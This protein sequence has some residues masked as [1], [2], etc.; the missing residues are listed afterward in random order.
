MGTLKTYSVVFNG[1]LRDC[2]KEMLSD[3]EGV[4][5]VYRCVYHSEADAV[6]L[7]E[8]IYIGKSNDCSIKQ[9]LLQKNFTSK[10]QSGEEIC[11]SL[12]EVDREDIDIVANALA[13]VQKPILNQEENH[14]YKNQHAHFLIGGQCELLK[15]TQFTIR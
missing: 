13:Y 1:Y 4:Y 9:E 11:Y 15:R 2:N 7:K 5:I 8:L 10:L 12:A 3:F 14:I 6:Q